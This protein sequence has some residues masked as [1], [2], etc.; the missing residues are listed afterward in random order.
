MDLRTSFPV[1]MRLGIM[2]TSGESSCVALNVA[3]APL[4]M[5]LK[6]I[7]NQLQDVALLLR[8][9]AVFGIQQAS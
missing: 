8:S 4:S 5:L 3:R 1:D 7:P 9:A 2:G 6:H